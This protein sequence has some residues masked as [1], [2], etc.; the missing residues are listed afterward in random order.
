MILK[1]IN[2]VLLRTKKNIYFFKENL[3]NVYNRKT[4]RMDASSKI[5]LGAKIN[6]RSKVIIGKECLLGSDVVLTSEI[7]S[8]IIRIGD[9]V[10]IN[11]NVKLDY[12][13]GLNIGNNTMISEDSLIYTHTHGYN[14]YSVPSPCPCKI[15]ANVWIGSRVI[16]VNGVH[17]GEGAI[18]ASGSVVTKDVEPYTIVGGNPAKLIKKLDKVVIEEKIKGVTKC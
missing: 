18:V 7:S 1:N 13:G 5:R 4:I 15:G 9:N 8:G 17:I 12:S 16:L 3:F 11:K 6:D 2:K 10:Q 14:P